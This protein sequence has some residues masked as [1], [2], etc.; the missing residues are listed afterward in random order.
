MAK[1][2]NGLLGG[3]SGTIGPAVGSKWKNLLIIRSRPPRKRRKS[4]EAQLKQMAKMGLVSSFVKPLTEFLNR[5]Y[6]LAVNMSSFNRAISY[7]MRN[8]IDGDRPAFKISYAR[9]LLGVGDLMQVEMPE[10]SSESKGELSF[11]WTD[12]S[13][14]G[15]A[16]ASDKAFVAVYCEDLKRW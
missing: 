16:N 11:R 14:V 6:P 4:S 13:G 9:V 10:V 12:N 7:N 15:S 8:A 5:N 1:L 3:L 2:P